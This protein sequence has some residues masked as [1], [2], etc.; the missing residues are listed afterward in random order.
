MIR[1]GS[2]YRLTIILAAVKS[3]TKLTPQQLARKR[4]NDRETQRTLRARTKKRIDSLQLEIDKLKSK[5]KWDYAVQ[6]LLQENKRL[7][8]ELRILKNALGIPAADDG[9]CGKNIFLIDGLG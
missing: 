9:S 1:L 7:E 2:A 8:G 4:A 3:V 6:E 5:T